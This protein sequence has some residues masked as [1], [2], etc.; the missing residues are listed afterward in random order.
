MN[1][2]LVPEDV[3]KHARPGVHL[4]RAAAAHVR[5][6]ATKSTPARCVEQMFGR[7]VV[8]LE[9][10]RSASAPA[11]T[12]ATGWAKELAGVAIYDLVQQATSQSAAAT[13]ID[14]GL[15]LNM[16]GIAEYH[17]PGR[18]L[19]AARMRVRTQETNGPQLP[20]LLRTRSD[21]P[22]GRRAADK[23]DELAPVHLGHGA[24]SSGAS[25]LPSRFAAVALGRNVYPQC[26]GPG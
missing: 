22:G 9:I 23:R 20:R 14:R 17:I 5:A 24:F 6:F 10:L 12:I 11:T 7:D 16:D 19:N 2:P 1:K 3:V 21:R 15:R 25:S 18:V 4:V 8:T 13:L 26:A